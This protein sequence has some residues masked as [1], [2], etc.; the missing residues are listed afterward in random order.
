MREEE[1]VS[2]ERDEREKDKFRRGRREERGM[3]GETWRGK[4]N[5]ER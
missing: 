2:L 1:R 5:R 3:R 4:N